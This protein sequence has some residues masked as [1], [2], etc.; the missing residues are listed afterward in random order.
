MILTRNMDY[1]I[2]I[3]DEKTWIK[4]M[5]KIENKDKQKIIQKIQELKK[6]PWSNHVSVKRLKH[7]DLADFRLRVGSF[8]VLFDC[9]EEKNRIVLYRGLHRSKLY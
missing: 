2:V 6:Y 1:S 3:A 8:R 5:N 7:Y 9:E 4:D